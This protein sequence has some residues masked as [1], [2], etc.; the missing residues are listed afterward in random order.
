[1][2]PRTGGRVKTT[3]PPVMRPDVKPLTETFSQLMA[4][5]DR[6]REFIA[7]HADLDL[8]R[9]RFRNPF[10]RGI[11]FSLAT[12]LNVIAAHDRRHVEQAE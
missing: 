12:G 11:R 1:M 9:I 10:A 7:R 5:Q 8:T 3:S 4:V 2:E 6:T